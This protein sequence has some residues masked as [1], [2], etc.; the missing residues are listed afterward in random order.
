M[1]ESF[2]SID[3]ITENDNKLYLYFLFFP[4]RWKWTINKKKSKIINNLSRRTD[5]YEF[6]Q[7]MN[8]DI[9]TIKMT[10]KNKRFQKYTRY[11]EYPL[12]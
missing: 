7:K 3:S 11:A 12:G 1:R 2:E 8:L 6:T 10:S 9:E 4:L 5:V